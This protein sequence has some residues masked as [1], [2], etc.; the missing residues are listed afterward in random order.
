MPPMTSHPAILVTGATGFI[1]SHTV[2][3]LAAA[4]HR[5]V[6]LD[7]FAN[8]HPG[9]LARLARLTG[10]AFPFYEG[11]L[12]DRNLLDHL[13]TRHGVAAVVHFA[14]LKAVGES[15]REP[16]PYYQANVAG[17]LE[18]LAAMAAHGCRNLV[19][20][21]SCTVYG[22][23]GALPIREDFPLVAT[24]PYGRTKLMTEEVCRD[25][26]AS[27]PGWHM[28]LLRYFNPV[29][30]HPSG[31]LGEDPRGAPNNLMPHLLQVA[32]GRRERL[33]VFGRDY[34]T[35]DGTGVRD[36]LH[37]VDLARGHVAALAALP[38][39]AGAVPINLGT[40]RGH[41]V[42][43]LVAAMSAA[44]G[45]P[46]PCEFGPRRPGDIACTWADP[47]RALERL[48]WRAERDLAAMCRD[49]WH[50]QCAQDRRAR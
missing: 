40:G 35:P 18:L 22:E 13:F 29:G 26:A 24:S 42:L 34:P 7:N 25:L 23:P 45:R 10:M 14:G 12:R 17:S 5:P 16:L 41:S 33:T 50:W 9:V 32:A 15:V 27:E 4:G 20:S 6:L 3:E 21:S 11:D 48:G 43:E 44:V 37:V 1:G 49:A 28:A 30:A 39:L 2:V 47:A 31:L 19:F 8:S 36:Y 46:I 38:A